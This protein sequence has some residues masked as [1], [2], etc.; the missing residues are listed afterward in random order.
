MSYAELSTEERVTNFGHSCSRC[1]P[2]T[3]SPRLEPIS[4][5]CLVL[6]VTW[7]PFNEL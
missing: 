1:E 4:L 2:P 3:S 7:L 5:P 6:A